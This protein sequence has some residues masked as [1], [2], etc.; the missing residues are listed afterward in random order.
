[1]NSPVLTS[2]VPAG[3]DLLLQALH[4]GS[5]GILGPLAGPCAG[6]VQY[7]DGRSEPIPPA[8]EAGPVTLPDLT[9]DGSGPSGLLVEGRRQ[10]AVGD[11]RDNVITGGAWTQILDGGHGNDTLSGGLGGDSFV[12]R[13]GQGSDTI[14]DFGRGWD[15]LRLVGTTFADKAGVLA[16]SV[17][18]GR[19]VI[20]DLGGG[21]TLTLKK[22]TLAKLQTLDIE[23][24]VLGTDG[25]DSFWPGSGRTLTVRGGEGN[26]SYYVSSS[27]TSVVEL[28]GEGVDTVNTWMNYTLGSNIENGVV[29]NEA[30]SRMLYLQGNGL[31]NTLRGGGTGEQILDGRGGN[32]TLTGGAGRDIFSVK[33]GEGSDVI[34]DFAGGAG[35]DLLRL[36]GF[37]FADAG[38]VLAAARQVGADVRIDLAAGQHLTL[39]NTRLEALTADN[40]ASFAPSTAGMTKL[41]GDEFDTLDLRGPGNP[42]GAWRPTYYWDNRT[43]EG[44]G[45]KQLYVDPSY[46]GLGL[47]PFSVKDGVLSISVS[48]TPAH[49]LAQVENKSYLSG[50]ITSEQSFSVQY[51]YFEMRAEMPEGTG[52]WPA[53]W[54]LP[55]DGS[56]PPEIDIFEVL[57]VDTGVLHTTVHSKQTGSH[58]SNGLGTLVGDTGKGMHT[59]GFDW[60][61][62]EMV[63]YY[64]GVEVFRADTPDD[65]HKP[66]YMLA[67]IAVGGWGGPVDADSFKDAQHT[68]MR[69][70]YV[71]A[72]ERP[73]E[74][75]AAALPPAWQSDRFDFARLDGTGAATKWDYHSRMASG[76]AKA[77]LGGD[78]ARWLTGNDRDNWL[79]GSNAQYNELD[80]RG[81]N[82]VLYGGGGVDTFVIRKG[83]G[84]DTVLD[85]S[86][87]DKIQLDGFHFRHIADVR[88]WAVQQGDDVILR[89][90]SDQAL[91]IADYDVEDLGAQSFFFTNV[92][93]AFS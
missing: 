24:S 82:D 32:D 89:L 73:A 44:N 55:I 53:W 20:I 70:D 50:A 37:G 80:G 77:K 1:M 26:D 69:I 56:W 41:F 54:M 48:E 5:T 15:Q 33:R 3:A 61:P 85:L 39:A 17:Q 22:M 71:R 68:D 2:P 35:G 23:L 87:D 58:T 52:L 6:P 11:A 16:A 78:W 46:K 76:E 64:D 88:A 92:Q 45:E 93:E 74:R 36:T 83:M 75:P 91:K 19:D 30:G 14:L 9:M 34:T 21:E 10:S 42:D 38:A 29:S 59:Y 60:G 8:L 86:G 63:W 66:F 40:I 72:Y 67:N 27:R 57:S 4:Q 47:N 84:N 90:S 12:V 31:A 62:E 28:A 18:S 49:L 13:R 65:A 25:N 43:L 51:G 79:G 81:G 7:L